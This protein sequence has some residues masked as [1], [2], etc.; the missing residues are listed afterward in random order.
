MVLHSVEREVQPF[1][2]VL[3]ALAR[4]LVFLEV[5]SAQQPDQRNRA[6]RNAEGA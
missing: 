6:D 2:G 1:L 4:P 5:Q 3:E